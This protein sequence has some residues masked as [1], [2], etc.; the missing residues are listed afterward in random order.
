MTLAPWLPW[1][2]R[3]GGPDSPNEAPRLCP[4][5]GDHVVLLPRIRRI[6]LQPLSLREQSGRGVQSCPAPG[7]VQRS[8]RYIRA[9]GFT[10]DGSSFVS[11][12]LAIQAYATEHK[13]PESYLNASRHLQKLKTWDFETSA[14]P[15]H[16]LDGGLEYGSTH[17]PDV[18]DIA[19]ESSNSYGPMGL[20]ELYAG[21][22]MT[23]TSRFHR[24]MSFM[25]V[26]RALHLAFK[27]YDRD[28][29]EWD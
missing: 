3:P 4:V 9:S 7:P 13:F 16:R 18:C 26:M 24:S 29:R 23:P 25:H 20:F 12:S 15:G 10:H 28:L 17:P 1:R 2:D 27:R 19:D 14:P 11:L 21:A 22:R 6:R 8:A 5:C